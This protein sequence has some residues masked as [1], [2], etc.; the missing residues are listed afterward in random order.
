MK[1]TIRKKL[2]GGFIGISVLLGSTIGAAYY[3]I[4]EVDSSYSDLLNR[5]SVIL[6]NSL[7]IQVHA[8]QQNNSLRGYLLSNDQELLKTQEN[9]NQQL[10][11][12]I[13]ETLP[14]VQD[15]GV[16]NGLTELQSLNAQYQ[17]N[18][19]DLLKQHAT[20][21]LGAIQVATDEVVPLG[22]K[23]RETAETIT[24]NQKKVVAEQGE[25]NHANVLKLDTFIFWM[26]L[27]AF[28]VAIVSGVVLAGRLSR[29]ITAMSAA[30]KRVA[31]GDLT[32]DEMSVNTR[33]EIEDL[34]GAFNQMTRN[35][36]TL[37]QAVGSSS[38][39]LAASTQELMASSQVTSQAAESITANIQDVAT[40]SEHQ[41]RIVTESS[42]EVGEM[43]K[44]VRYIADSADS[45]TTSALQATHKAEEG[46]QAIQTA[47][48]QMNLIN[49]T[50]TDLSSRIQ[51]LGE[52]S[53][54]ISLI[55]ETISGIAAQT[56]LLALNAAIEASRAGEE[57]RGFAVVAD[58]VR[59]LAEQSSVSAKQITD[60]IRTIQHETELAVRSME[61]GTKEIASG[62][63]V[64]QTAGHS[65]AEVRQSVEGVSGQIQSVN[66]AA[67]QLAA[68]TEQVINSMRSIAE[69]AQIASSGTQLVA[70]STEEQTAS[71]QEISAAAETLA[72]MAEDLNKMVL[73]FRL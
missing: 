11:N 41:V 49:Q 2:L 70:A 6:Q 16:K 1:F 72:R 34:A 66:A 37:I 68:S 31:D 21:K 69:V 46:N 8:V 19:A 15:P 28:A 63:R 9:A 17:Q 14:M 10:A 53:Q 61:T 57:G 30:A 22:I 32:G 62:M 45:V 43:T 23:L 73:K 5:R 50:M 36:R 33:D 55:V 18:V 38:Q 52:R 71:M 40:G 27:G 4:N 67:S 13:A 7:N 60:L 3:A 65:F 58:E 26:S 44:G 59:K 51:G 64:V 12:L 24:T 42:E 56:N 29:P 48:K 39:Q 47:T 54:E 35:L 20:D 25:I